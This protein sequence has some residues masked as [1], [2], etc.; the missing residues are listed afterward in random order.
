MRILVLNP[1]SSS[2][3]VSVLEPPGRDPLVS[4]VVDWGADATRSSGPASAVQAVDAAVGKAGLSMSSIDAVGYRVVH[5]GTRFTKPTVIDDAV[6]EAIEELAIF[7]PLHN[8]IAAATIRAF[9]DRLSSVPHVAGFDTGFHATLPPAGYRYPVP[10]EWFDSWGVRRFG[11]HGLSVAWSVQ[12][13]AELLDRP[14]DD[15][16]LVVAHL[17]SGCSVTAVD[18][19]RSVDTSMGMTPLEG[20]MM[21]SRAGSIDPGI[22]I[23]LL[24]RRRETLSELADT[25]DHQ[26]GL[27]G[28]SGRSADVRELL[29]AEAEG[30][31]AAAL[32]LELFVRRAAAGIASSATVLPVLDAVIFTGGIG[33]HSGPIRARIVDSLAVLGIRR[34]L[35]VDVH[36]DA[37]CSEPHERPAVLRVA[38]REDVLIAAGV[39][40]LL[41]A[42]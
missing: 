11:F 31:E 39:R 4:A 15:L 37:L 32:A 18:S 35:D 34:I 41:E 40:D 28:V 25:L 9:R 7:A 16:R 29:V 14:I 17:G 21:G 33:E 42:A 2:L 27:L 30:D 6:V 36:E 1:G 22:L 10:S 23:D 3:K 24:R 38:A 5:G 8:R 20:L 26:S 12:R 13:A 19:G